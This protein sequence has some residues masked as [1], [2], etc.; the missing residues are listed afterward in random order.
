LVRILSP[1]LSFIQQGPQI[2]Q[3]QYDRIMKHI[4][5]GK[6]E[7]ATLLRGGDKHG[8]EGFFIQPTVFSDVHE[9]HTIFKEEIFGPVV[10]ITKFSSDEEVIRLANQTEYG[11]ASAVFS[12]DISRAIGVA[13]KVCPSP[14][15]SRWLSGPDK[16]AGD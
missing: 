11:L 1:P 9:D 8:D 16:E 6:K 5:S 15:L 14:L 3:T 13:N 4:D 2:S 12:R 7:G 10:A